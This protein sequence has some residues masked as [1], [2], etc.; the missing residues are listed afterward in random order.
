MSMVSNGVSINNSK[1][2]GQAFKN[3]K[4]IYRS[5]LALQYFQFTVILRNEKV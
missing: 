2:M 3:S 1:V 5:I 4:I